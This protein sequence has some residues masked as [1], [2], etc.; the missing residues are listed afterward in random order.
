MKKFLFF[1]M[2]LPL[3]FSC[4]QEDELNDGVPVTKGLNVSADFISLANTGGSADA[5]S[6]VIRSNEKEVT[7]KWISGASFNIDTT[8][9]V[10]SM[11]DGQG[12][13]PIKWQK[14]LE[15]G[16]YAPENIMFKAGVVLTAG[17]FERY[18]PL[19][20][21]QNLDSASVRRSLQ[22]RAEENLTPKVSS[23]EF[24][25]LYPAMSDNGATV[26]VR[27]TNLS[28]AQ[29]DY[30]SIKSFHN[31]DINPTDTPTELV[32]GTNLIKFKWK[33]ANVRPAAFNLP[34][35]FSSFELVGGYAMVMLA[36][37]PGTP[38]VET[39]TYVSST[40]PEGNI[41]Q[42]GGNYTF[43]FEGN[44]TGSIQVRAL[45]EGVVLVT[46]T[47]DANLHPQVVVPAN[48]ATTERAITF[49]YLLDNGEW[50]ALPMTTN[51]M[52]DG[53][54]ST[55]T[56]TTSKII[57]AGAIP[58]KGNTYYCQFKGG[59]GKVIFRAVRTRINETTGQEVVRSD[60]K[61]VPATIGLKIPVLDGLNAMISFE[62]S[63]DGG[64]NW[65]SL[66]D[67]R[68]QE[69][70]W[71][72]V[73]APDANTRIDATNGSIT[74]NLMGDADLALT[75][76]AKSNGVIVGQA[77]GYFPS[78]VVVPVQDNPGNTERLISFSWSLNNGISWASATY[79]QAG[80]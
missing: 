58:E 74:F 39:V 64:R 6:L 28:Q 35:V 37:D 62:Y 2:I 23:I 80:K 61:A 47:A 66:N 48:T 40:L 7:V 8:Q 32:E 41:P 15:N 60:E 11:K 24:L 16:S 76:Y 10:V 70:T 79:K 68:M 69:N 38:P 26:M 42:A 56:I 18:I 75:I 21:V 72:F 22:T 14:K 43:T 73:S 27:L 36:W 55:G 13:L 25:P 31:I 57:P 46:G 53:G 54:S 33:D 5:S 4:S 67:D 77:T 50:T 9:T 49:E 65:I 12:V 30:S 34:I 29:A 17:E 44:Y 78:E 71:A 51:R 3:V 52:Q 19:Y 45:S 1:L 63:I 20:H 59:P